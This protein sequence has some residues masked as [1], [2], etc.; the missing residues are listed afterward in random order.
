MK[1]FMAIRPYPSSQYVEYL[2]EYKSFSFPKLSIIV[3]KISSVERVV[4]ERISN[5]ADLSK[6]PK[7]F[8]A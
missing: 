2:G 6:V 7:V 8:S 3:I 5:P 1:S 4:Y